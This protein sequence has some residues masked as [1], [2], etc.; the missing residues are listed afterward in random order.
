MVWHL[1]ANVEKS[2]IWKIL[3]II[4][5]CLCTVNLNTKGPLNGLNGNRCPTSLSEL[6]IAVFILMWNFEFICICVQ[7]WYWNLYKL[8]ETD[9]M[10]YLYYIT[11]YWYDVMTIHKKDMWKFRWVSSL[12]ANLAQVTSYIIHE[13]NIIKDNE[14]NE[15]I[16]FKSVCVNLTMFLDS[17]A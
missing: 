1:V 15:D 17:T 2:H 10:E 11:H 7:Q 3:C 9:W 13:D 14:D 5:F 12:Y 6:V 8:T 16:I 4:K